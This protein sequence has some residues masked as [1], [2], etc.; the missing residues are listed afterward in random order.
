[1]TDSTAR[2]VGPRSAAL[3]QQLAGKDIDREQLLAYRYAWAVAEEAAAGALSRFAARTGDPLHKRLADLFAREVGGSEA[4][5]AD[6]DEAGRLVLEAGGAGGT[7]LDD[8]HQMIA[9]TFRKYAEQ[10]VLP[11]AEKVHREDLL[12]PEE[13]IA[14]LREL[15]C[16]GLSI[17]QK[18]GGFQ[19]DQKPDNLGM[20]VVT[21]ELSRGSLGIAGSLITRPEILAKALLKGGTDAQKQRLLP[22]IASGEKM[23]SVCATEPDFGSDVAGMKVSATRVEDGFLLNGVKTWATF[24]GRA[25]LMMVLARTDPDLGKKHKGL[26]ILIAEKPPFPGHHFEYKQ[27]SREG[28]VEGRA[29]GTIGYRGMHS[30]EVSFE[31]FY[32]PIENVI[33]GEGGLGKGFYLQMEGFSGGRLQ[34][35]ARAVGVMQAAFEAA[36]RYSGER[37]VFGAPIG[38]YQL[39]RWKLARMAM[40][41]QASRQLSYEAAAALDKHD[42]A[43][44]FQASLVKLFASKVAEWVTRE[45][46]QVHGG[47]GY[48]EEYAVSRYFVDARVFSIFEGAEE[49]LALKVIARQLLEAK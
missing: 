12:I 10:N 9:E 30:Y 7:G 26:S 40:L 19:D 3:R 27:P 41:V 17:P 45:A 2:S 44:Q 49:I 21:E 39:T 23:V 34:T 15:G 22:I 48:A 5:P 31:N 47:M 25:E 14:G 11:I 42:Q 20:V 32:V 33:G 8:D 6:Y 36:R 37:K 4:P 43:G 24:A 16:F 18:Y 46:Q 28:K 29:I 35:A 13:I 38:D 1:M